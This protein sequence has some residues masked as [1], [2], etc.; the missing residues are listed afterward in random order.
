MKIIIVCI[1]LVCVLAACTDIVSM[2]RL[3]WEHRH[4]K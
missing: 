2:I 3:W 1:V 4:D